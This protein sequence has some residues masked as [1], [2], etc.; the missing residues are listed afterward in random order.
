MEAWP[1]SDN[2]ERPCFGCKVFDDHPRHE[3]I[4]P[5]TGSDVAGGPMHMDCCA[6]KRNC[7]IC[8]ATREGLPADLIGEPFREHLL[9][10][11]AVEVA[12]ADASPFSDVT[13]T[14]V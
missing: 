10:Q 3:I 11:P 13:V 14:E 12:H 8:K 5:E 7:A 1:M 2:P 9:A 4:D 6:E